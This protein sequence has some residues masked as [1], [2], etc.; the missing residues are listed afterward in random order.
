MTRTNRFSC[1]SS[2]GW[3]LRDSAYHNIRNSFQHPASP[4]RGDGQLLPGDPEVSS[5]LHIRNINWGFY[6]FSANTEAPLALANFNGT[7]TILHLDNFVVDDIRFQLPRVQVLTI[8]VVHIPNN[9]LEALSQLF[10][11][12]RKLS[13]QSWTTSDD[14]R[15]SNR[16]EN[17]AQLL[18]LSGRWSSLGS[19]D[20]G[21][22]PSLPW[23]SYFR[24]P[25]SA[26]H[27]VLTQT[28]STQPVI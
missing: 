22:W 19:V 5:F 24:S 4:P 14:P 26:P 16:E 20:G 18:R 13:F 21:M 2:G 1:R 10:P 3:A 6:I 27:L 9:F 7:L 11:N 15:H 23:A 17:H 12:L 25:I 8:S 28:P